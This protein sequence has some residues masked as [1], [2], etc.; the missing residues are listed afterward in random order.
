MVVAEQIPP[1]IQLLP[2]GTSKGQEAIDLAR[3]L[4][5]EADWHQELVIREGCKTKADGRWAAFEV[6]ICE[7][8]QNGKGGILEIR[9]LA[10]LFLWDEQLIV[11]SA[12]QFD[13]SLEAFFRMLNLLEES[14]L[15]SY[16]KRVSKSHGE[17]GIWLKSGQRLRYRTRTKGGGRGFSCDTLILDEGMFLS[18]ASHGALIPTMRA[19]SNPQVWYAGSAVDQVFH[20]HGVVFSR[21]RERGI[22]GQDKSLAYFEWSLDL[23]NPGEVTEDLKRDPE[24]WRQSNP[25]LG[26][27]IW[28]EHIAKEVESMD[29]RTFAVEIL[30]VGDWPRT[31]GSNLSPISAEE[32]G[33]LTDA[34]SKLLDPICLAFDV[35]PE[36]R[37]A[38]AAAG[39]RLDGLWHVELVSAWPGTKW[40]PDKLAS[41][42]EEHDPLEVV[43]DGYG[44]AS[45]LVGQLAERGVQV[46]TL[47]SGQHS[48]ACGQLADLVVERG[49]RHLGSPEL[50]NA[51]KGAATR[52]LG[53]A[54]AWSRKSSVVDI[55]PLVAVTLALYSAQS[56]PD[57]GGDVRIY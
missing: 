25:A 51:L 8:R 37:T 15:E 9:E 41:L 35:S 56:Q 2:E 54:W 39:R 6:G 48:Q 18:E 52:P 47:S 11:H 16:I 17:E 33:L 10:G 4:G 36:R 23:E 32:W 46:R 19:R 24:S 38:I 20:E 45:S 50:A 22:K 29:T 12:H 57:D 42:V 34:G 14:R 27:R 21:L 31:D 5:L 53:D 28:P 43:C 1:R 49:L 55:S 30:G 26:I 40:L 3:E 44:P 7:P 13:T